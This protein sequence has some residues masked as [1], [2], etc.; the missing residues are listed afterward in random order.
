[1]LSVPFMYGIS[2]SP[3]EPWSFADLKENA[4]E[5]IRRICGELFDSF[6]FSGPIKLY[7]KWG[8]GGGAKVFH[9]LDELPR[10]ASDI[11]GSWRQ[12]YCVDV[13][14]EIEYV[15]G[16]LRV[17]KNII[18]FEVGQPSVGRIGAEEIAARII[19]GTSLSAVAQ[20]RRVKEAARR[21]GLNVGGDIVNPVFYKRLKRKVEL[22]DLKSFIDRCTALIR[23][24]FSST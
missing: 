7:T 22:E 10:N 2:G 15:E 24:V 14:G 3:P 5:K 23:E 6:G 4:W 21:Y 9:S 19:A 1:M 13:R 11:P 20:M 17:F 8:K 12:I 16:E 18:A